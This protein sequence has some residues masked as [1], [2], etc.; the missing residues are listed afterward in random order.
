MAKVLYSN[1][2]VNTGFFQCP[3]PSLLKRMTRNIK[4]LVVMQSPKTIPQLQNIQ[5]QHP[6]Q[7]KY[8][9]Q[10][11]QTLKTPLKPSFLEVP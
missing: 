7:V 1:V 5:N 2:P 4:N 8:A 10:N 6:A 3:F 11:K 9:G